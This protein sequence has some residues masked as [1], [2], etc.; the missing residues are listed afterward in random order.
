MI[1]AKLINLVK[2]K[3]EEINKMN[4]KKEM[5]GKSQIK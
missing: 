2:L 1:G 3:G 5:W 4:I